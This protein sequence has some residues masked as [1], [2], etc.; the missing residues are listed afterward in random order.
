MRLLSL[1]PLL[2]TT[3]GI[4]AAHTLDGD[5]T[6][7]AQLSH[8]LTGDHHLPVFILLTALVLVLACRLRNRATEENRNENP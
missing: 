5:A 8:Q 3:G 6:I 4:A 1:L 7:Q 2:L